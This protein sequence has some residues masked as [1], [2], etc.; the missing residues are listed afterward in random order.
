MYDKTPVVA[1]ISKETGEARTRVVANVQGRTLR[2]AIAEDVDL[3][4]AVLHTDGHKGYRWA[5]RDAAGHEFVDH[6]SYEYVRGNVSTNMAESFFAQFKRSV[7]GTFHNVSRQHLSRYA[8]EFA[9]RW[10]TSKMTDAQRVQALV[11][12]TPGRRLT[13]RPLRGR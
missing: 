10:N 7:D 11:D 12:N 2:K 5:S 1:L 8:D 3:P 6:S 4:N 9:F 13:Y